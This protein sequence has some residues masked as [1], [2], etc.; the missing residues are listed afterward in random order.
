MATAYGWRHIRAMTDLPIEALPTVSAATRKVMQANKRRDTGPEMKVRRWLHTRGFRFR[1]D[2]AK[3]KGRLDQPFRLGRSNR[4]NLLSR[5]SLGTSPQP[6]LR[7]VLH[8]RHP[9]HGSDWSSCQA[10]QA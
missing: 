10:Q 5:K 3:L 4:F 9:V 6:S 8:R 2:Y 7:T 1:V